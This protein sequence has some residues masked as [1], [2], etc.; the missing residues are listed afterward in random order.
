MASRNK[1]SV[2]SKEFCH[3]DMNVSSRR[4]LCL[5]VR[6]ISFGFVVIEEPLLLLDWG[7]RRFS[8]RNLMQRPLESKI[9]RILDD[10]HPHL[11][12]VNAP[13]VDS[14]RRATA[15]LE[16]I[17]NQRSLPVTA[18]SRSDVRHA[19]PTE[20]ENKYEIAAAIAERLPSLRPYLP[21]RRRAW[22]AEPYQMRVFDAAA[23]ALA[24][25]DN[26]G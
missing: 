6:C 25:L 19:F 20:N 13:I 9:E 26:M 4:V 12:L 18:L 15:V 11:V 24:H 16:Q 10:H 17:I 23:I 3:P 2:G 14:Q 8:L 1:K 21:S 7:V 5:N 22:E